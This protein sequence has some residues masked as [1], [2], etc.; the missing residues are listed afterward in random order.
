M[1]ATELRDH[2]F[3]LGIDIVAE[4][5]QLRVGAARG[6]LTENIQRA[7]A[8]HRA[9]LLELLNN[10]PSPSPLDL[11]RVPRIDALP[12]SFF[13]E[14]LWVL[15]RLEPNNIDYNMV[16]VWLGGATANAACLADRIR[17]AVR[18]H[19]ILRSTFQ[20]IDGALRVKILP[21]DLTVIEIKILDELDEEEQRRLISSTIDAATRTPFD[22]AAEA[23]VRFTVYQ[24]ASGVTL[25]QIAAHHI[26]L[27]AWSLALLRHEI[28]E[29]GDQRPSLAATA[30]AVHATPFQYVDFA[31]WQRR[32]FDPKAIASQLGWWERRLAGIPQLC[33]FPPD[34]LPQSRNTGSARF[35][36]WSGDLLEAVRELARAEGATLYMALLA[37]CS[38][39]LRAHTG[40]SDIV[41]GS[42]MGVRERPEFEGM[43]G[44]FINLLVMRIDL[45]DDPVFADV[46]QS[47]RD[48]VLDAHAHR[49]VPFELLIERLRPARNFNHHPLFQVAVVLHNASGDAGE[50]IHSGGA[51]HD[52]T[53]FAR[54]VE[55][56]LENTIEFR[57][58]LYTVEA[59]DRIASHLEAVLRA[60]ISNRHRR[61]SEISLLTAQEQEKVNA[62]FNATAR[63]VD[64]ATFVEQ[65]ERQAVVSARSR[66]ISF[67]GTEL[68]YEA[69]NRRANQLAR[70][71]QSLAIGKGAFVGLC[72]DRTPD[73][74]V[75]LLAI[76]KA[77]AAYVPLDP[78]FPAERLEYMLADSSMA[79]LVTSGKTAAGLGI[80]QGV[81]LLDLAAEVSSFEEMELDQSHGGG[82][83]GRPRLRHLYIR[84]PWA[85]KRR[86]H[87]ARRALEFPGLDEA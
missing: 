87:L 79:M 24:N 61:L 73:L 8:A 26:A 2:L 13:Q 76:Q 57:S 63:D 37:A 6:K 15:H 33:V 52:L 59:I 43:I 12:L 29:G 53:W 25:V 40:Q 46:L 16:V 11:V 78:S 14:R 54:E 69:L 68:S 65:F 23:P 50:P 85:A 66:A 10:Q 38:V 7:I 22:L 84:V 86:G 51:I 28:I 1:N 64:R 30:P 71:L 70:Y 60:A 67:E 3:S 47:A 18:R 56:R 9:E 58:D 62:Q 74:V 75:A 77:G 55:G 21:E 80:P 44:P 72:L 19:E 39:V 17:S 31:A 49:D 32:N 35:F 20:E 41:L 36:S 27:D 42:P 5:G 82:G 34:K 81:R 48:A 83:A 4:G 45:A